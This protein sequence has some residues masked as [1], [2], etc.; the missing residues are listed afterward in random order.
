MKQNEKQKD[1]ITF[2]M[3]VIGIISLGE[4]VAYMVL[5]F[6]K[7]TFTDA[8]SSRLFLGIVCLGFYAILN[9]MS[10]NGN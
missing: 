2:L 1:S 3:L 9:K 7:D 5:D 8:Y 10:K 4:S 6:I